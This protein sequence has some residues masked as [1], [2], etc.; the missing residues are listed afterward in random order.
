M[1]NKNT[2]IAASM[3]DAMARKVKSA[4]KREQMTLSEFVRAAL[5]DRIE[6]KTKKTK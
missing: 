6:T 3:P 4:A 5:R 2:L 1:S